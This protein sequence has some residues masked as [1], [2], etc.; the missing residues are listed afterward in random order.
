M[1]DDELRKARLGPLYQP[2][3]TLQQLADAFLDQFQGAPA[4]KSWLRYYLIKPTDTFG[5][6]P[7]GELNALAIAQ[8]RVKMLEATRHGAHRAL[9]Q[10][11]ASAVRWQ[12]IERNAALDVKNPLHPR[13]EFV[14]FESW[15]DVDAV[16]R[17]CPFGPVAIFCVSTGV[18]PEEAFGADWM[19][20]D[21]AAGV[22]TI[23]RAYA[24]GKLKT[25]AKTARP[26]RRVPIRR[27]VIAALETIPGRKGTVL[28]ALGG[29]QIDINNWRSRKWTPALKAAG[30]EH[31][32]IY[33]M[34]HTFATWSL[35]A[36]MSIFTL[37]RRMGT[38]VPVID[39][40]YGHLA[41][42][43]DGDDRELLDAY[44]EARGT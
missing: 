28:P 35:A 24:K 6:D 25:Y 23:R 4:S 20:L 29:G 8:W 43:A 26:R 36:G 18:R 22:F 9:R 30:V 14:P 39:A 34:R 10:V 41:I 12:W 17:A 40:T 7:L 11:L 33:D 3:V 27:K 37:A 21:P 31:R 13:A 1:L 44:D 19:D 32:R 5:N 15:D 42:D 2:D 38:S 16:G